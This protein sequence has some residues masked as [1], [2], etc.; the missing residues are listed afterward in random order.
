MCDGKKFCVAGEILAKLEDSGDKGMHVGCPPSPRNI[1]S[2]YQTFQAC[3]SET[4][5]KHESPLSRLEKGAFVFVISESMNQSQ[6]LKSYS[7]HVPVCAPL[8]RLGLDTTF[9]TTF[10]TT[11]YLPTTFHLCLFLF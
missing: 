1:M 7:P 11:F 6:S 4:G 8:C 9:H 5:N 2:L 10:H 3:Q